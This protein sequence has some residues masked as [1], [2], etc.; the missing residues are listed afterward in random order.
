MYIENGAST[1]TSVTFTSTIVTNVWSR[2]SGSMV[3]SLSSTVSFTSTSS[4]Y[5]CQTAAYG[6]NN[7]T[8]ANQLYT[9]GGAFYIKDAVKFTSNSNTY[10]YCYV[11]DVGG[12]FYIENS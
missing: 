6:S 2:L 10:Q 7:P 5:S 3:Y 1:L 12:A 9:Q 8:L 4:S 11:S